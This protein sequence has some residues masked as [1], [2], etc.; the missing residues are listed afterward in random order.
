MSL[1][2]LQLAL[3]EQDLKLQ[4]ARQKLA[5]AEADMLQRQQETRVAEALCAPGGSSDNPVILSSQ[6]N[7]SDESSLEEPE[8]SDAPPHP[9]TSS[10]QGEDTDSSSLSTIAID[11]PN[12]D[13]GLAPTAPVPPPRRRLS[14]EAEVARLFL[15]DSSATESAET[16]SDN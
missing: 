6:D 16:S 10:N 1:S 3:M 5:V 11:D 13:R 14:A 8:S 12:W 15:L 4:E 7:S 2:D 9:E